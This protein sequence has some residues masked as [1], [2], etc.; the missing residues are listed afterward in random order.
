MSQ[1]RRAAPPGIAQ[2]QI[3]NADGQRNWLKSAPKIKRKGNAVNITEEYLL[4]G[5]QGW[6][7]SIYSAAQLT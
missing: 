2:F 1:D 6:L 7:D 5:P 4:S 3:P